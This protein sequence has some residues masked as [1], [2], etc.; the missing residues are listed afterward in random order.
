MTSDFQEI[1]Y[2]ELSKKIKKV[3]KDLK[4]TQY[5]FA[6][7]LGLS[8]ASIV[9]IEKERQKPTIHLLYNI[10]HKAKI[11][12]NFFFDSIPEESAISSV[13]KRIEKKLE[14]E[15]DKNAQKTL[16]KFFS[17]IDKNNI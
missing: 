14:R 12:M 2:S 5:D 17:K 11:E 7:I 6:E 1:F 16:L 9:N 3:R 8:R 4:M 13:S 15:L 10:A